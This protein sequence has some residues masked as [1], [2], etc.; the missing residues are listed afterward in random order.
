MCVCFIELIDIIEDIIYNELFKVHGQ[1][2]TNKG[3]EVYMN[4]S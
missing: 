1:F 2:Y 4:I 3:Q